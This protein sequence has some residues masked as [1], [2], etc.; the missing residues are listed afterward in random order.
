[1]LAHLLENVSKVIAQALARR[2]LLVPAR[3]V[4]A[5]EPKGSFLELFKRW[6]IVLGRKQVPYNHGGASRDVNLV[7]GTHRMVVVGAVLVPDSSAL[8]AFCFLI[9][10]LH[11]ASPLIFDACSLSLHVVASI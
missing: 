10:L 7:V 3:Q 2:E 9:F 4:V 6:Q 5:V 1:M 8:N 11:P